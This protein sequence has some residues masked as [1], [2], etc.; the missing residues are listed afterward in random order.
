MTLFS[1]VLASDIVAIAAGA[2]FGL[3]FS[4][5]HTTQGERGPERSLTPSPALRASSPVLHFPCIRRDV[6]P[7]AMKAAIGGFSASLLRDLLV[8]KYHPAVPIIFGMITV[9]KS[10]APLKV[11]PKSDPWF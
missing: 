6:A 4:N 10:I 5:V 8:P 9:A 7:I 2:A 11:D 1:R 3:S